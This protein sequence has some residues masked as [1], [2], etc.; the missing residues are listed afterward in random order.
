MYGTIVYWCDTNTMPKKEESTFRGHYPHTR[1]K[2]Y[3][4]EVSTRVCSA[5]PKN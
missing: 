1:S 2:K 4:L 5:L 3:I